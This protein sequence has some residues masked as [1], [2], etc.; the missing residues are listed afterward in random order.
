MSYKG[1]TTIKFLSNIASEISENFTGTNG[2]RS[3][4]HSQTLRLR[5][6]LGVQLGS[7]KQ[8]LNVRYV[9]SH[10]KRQPKLGT[11]LFTALLIAW[12]CAVVTVLH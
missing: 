6:L 9:C 7:K 1:C 2:G 4:E 12:G 11:E 10:S 5:K 8:R 3:L